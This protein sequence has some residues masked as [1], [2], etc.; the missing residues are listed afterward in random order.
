[1]AEPKLLPPR[2]ALFVTE[3]LLD[4]NATQAAIR[5]GYSRRT[6][7]SQGDRLLKNVEIAGAIDRARAARSGRTQVSADR[8]LLE[9]ARVAFGDARQLFDEYGALRPV[10]E[11]G[12]EIAAA[13]SSV[14]VVRRAA[15]DGEVEHVHKVRCWDKVRALEVLA[16]HLG[17]LTERVDVSGTVAVGLG[18]LS[19]EE[20]SALREYA[21]QR[22]A[23]IAGAR[24]PAAAG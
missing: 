6:A 9:L 2:Q 23:A 5:S 15:G 18:P 21:E 3:Y 14:E 10:R 19:A 8:V 16:K 13:L 1:M 7:A 4:L 17:M 11:L 12:D 22:A 24:G 20:R